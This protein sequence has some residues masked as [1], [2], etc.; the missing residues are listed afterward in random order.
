MENGFNEV[1]K[2]KTEED[3]NAAYVALKFMDEFHKRR[4]N[5]SFAEALQIFH[6]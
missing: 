6:A 3:Y 2:L 5:L 4:K 1:K